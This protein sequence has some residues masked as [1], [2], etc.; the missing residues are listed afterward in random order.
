M[1]A[2]VFN[3]KKYLKIGGGKPSFGILRIIMDALEVDLTTFTCQSNQGGF[4]IKAP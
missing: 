3:L 1:A 2:I 4:I